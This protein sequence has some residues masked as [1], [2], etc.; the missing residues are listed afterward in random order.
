ME[1]DFIPL[2][3]EPKIFHPSSFYASDMYTE[4]SLDAVCATVKCSSCPATT[5]R[6]AVLWNDE[7]PDAYDLTSHF[8]IVTQAAFYESITLKI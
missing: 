3:N 2:I 1:T 5:S 8:S 6:F 7:A 4:C